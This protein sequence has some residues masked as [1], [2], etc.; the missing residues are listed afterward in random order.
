M[1][2]QQLFIG[3]DLGTSGCRVIAINAQRDIVASAVADLPEPVHNNNHVEQDPA[4]WWDAVGSCLSELTTRINPDDVKAIAVDGTSATLFL[5]DKNNTPLTPALM[6]NDARA[7]EQSKTIKEVAP[8]D[9]AAQGATC[10]LAKLLWFFNSTFNSIKTDEVKYAI[11]QAD[12][13]SAK[14]CNQPGMS[15][16]NNALKLGFDA[17][18]KA[19]PDWMTRLLEENNIPL[20]ILPRV[21]KPG[22][23]VGHLTPENAKRFNLP[24]TTQVIAGTTDSTAS[25]IATGANEIGD[26]V[27]SLGSTLVVKVISDKAVFA[28]EYGVYSQP[29]AVEGKERWLV[30]GASNSGGAVLKQYFSLDQLTAMTPL[31]DP[32]NTTGLD[33]YPLPS[34]GE[35]FPVNDPDLEPKLEPRPENDVTFFQGILEGIARIEARG[36][37]LLA[38]LGA[39]YPS[40][41]RTTGGGA[42]NEAWTAIRRTMLSESGNSPT[43][44]VEADQTQAA[45]GAAI[46]ALAGS[47]V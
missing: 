22:T 34:I 3:I 13:I 8:A 6:Y 45:Y 5:T 25:F 10:A 23:P 36:Y 18:K 35:R 9:T 31:L 39:P 1:A 11:H 29:L 47:N 41:V 43:K 21:V 12:W 19:W 33:F 28:P 7:T 37:R 44:M 30:G 4:L 14:L 32:E 20:G 17:E 24:T 40:T 38:E 42:S 26:A 15:D 27:T 2:I 16:Y 46:L